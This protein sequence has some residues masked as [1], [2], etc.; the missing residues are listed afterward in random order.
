MT[1]PHS[2]VALPAEIYTYIWSFFIGKMSDEFLKTTNQ[3]RGCLAVDLKSIASFML[4]DKMAKE[5][6]Y[7]LHGWKKV[8]FSLFEECKRLASIVRE[9]KPTARLNKIAQDLRYAV[10]LAVKYEESII[11]ESRRKRKC[12]DDTWLCVGAWVGIEPSTYFDLQRDVGIIRAILPDK[13]AAIVESVT[14]KPT[15]TIAVDYLSIFPPTYGDMVMVEGGHVRG[16]LVLDYSR[17]TFLKDAEG[18]F[19]MVRN[20]QVIKIARS[21]RDDDNVREYLH[22][23]GT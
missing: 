14:N 6:F 7:N 16:E 21:L 1:S 23:V 8:T 2:V 11:Q 19:R 9:K 13:S 10:R 5:A 3:Q 18:R 22:A 4:V 20:Q 17:E 15:K 12:G